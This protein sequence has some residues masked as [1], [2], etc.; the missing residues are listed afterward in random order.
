MAESHIYN[1][2]RAMSD[3]KTSACLGNGHES[4]QSESD[5]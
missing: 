2:L 3:A 1:Y 4:K 5:I